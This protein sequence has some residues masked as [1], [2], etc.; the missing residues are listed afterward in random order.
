MEQL[1]LVL[2]SCLAALVGLALGY[3][4]ARLFDRSR[5]KSVRTQAEQIAKN[6]REEAE[7]IKEGSRTQ[8]QGRPLSTTR[9][10]QPRNRTGARRT[11]RAGTPP[12]QARRRP[13]GEDPRPAKTRTHAGQSQNQAERTQERG[14]EARRGGGEADRAADAASCTRSPASTASR[15]RQLLLERLERELA[16]Q[17]AARIQKHE[18]QLQPGQRGEE[19]AHPGDGHPAL[20]RRA[21]RRHHRQHGGHSQRRHEG[22]HHRPRGPQHPH[23]RERH[24][25][26]RHRR[27]HARR[28]HRQRLRQRPPRDRPAGPDQADPGRPHSSLAHR[29]SRQGNAGGDGEAHPGGRQAG[30]AWRRTSARC[31][32]SWCSCWAG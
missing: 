29:G 3:A 21:H 31:T 16:E 13:G 32:R 1:Y 11:A 7:K 19:P 26:R 22:P 9:G 20:R 17:I 2:S 27:R 18:E 15:P 25:R 5:L 8:G 14:R 24:R 28:R 6:A 30:G 12:R 23:L 10:I 4:G